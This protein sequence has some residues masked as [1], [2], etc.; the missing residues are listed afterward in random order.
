MSKPLLTEAFLR[1]LPKTDLHVHLDG[2]LRPET[3]LELAAERKVELPSQTVE[4]LMELVFKEQYRDLPEYLQG[5]AYTTAVLQDPESLARCAY[6]LCQDAQEE[7]VR[8]MEIRFAP[9]LHTRPGF[10]IGEVLQA[11]ASGMARAEKEFNQRPEVMRGSEP[12]FR[13][14]ILVCALRFFDQPF[15]RTYRELLDALADL[16]QEKVF[17]LASEALVRASVRA[18]DDFGV[19]VVGVDLAGQEKG[20]PAEDH[21]EAYRLAHQAFLGKTVHAG[22]DYGPES[23]FQAITECYA[24]RIGHGTW[25]FQE[26]RIRNSAIDDPGAYIDALVQYIAD[27]RITMEVCLSSNL[28]T[29]PVL[30]KIED[31]P[32]GKM[33]A[34]K[35]SATFC[36]DNRLVTRTSVTREVQRAVAAFHLNAKELGDLLV[37][38]FKRS[39]FPGPYLEK[40]QYVREVLDYRDAVFRKFGVTPDPT[41]HG[42]R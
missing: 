29:L 25:L 37:Y 13:A 6:E 30:G 5:F 42:G 22:E 4:G 32:F 15:S 17:G 18:R 12:P 28:Q 40:R 21:R 14:G 8:Y 1:A 11:V 7:G 38:G 3:L 33:R 36:T 39:F 10:G 41:A 26:D 24:D 31:H 20:Y 16:P 2:S 27:R 34:A 9:Q 23:I 19:A 35:L